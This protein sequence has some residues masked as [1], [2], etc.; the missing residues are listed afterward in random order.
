V[1]E[2]AVRDVHAYVGPAPS[3]A[4][5]GAATSLGEV[6]AAAAAAYF[7]HLAATADGRMSD[8][9]IL[10]AVIADSADVWR[11]LLGVSRDNATRGRAT[12]TNAAIWVSRFAAVKLDGHPNDL[13]WRGDEER[14]GDDARGSAVFALS[15][16]RDREG[17]PPL[18]QVARTNRDAYLRRQ[19]L[20][21]L[22]QS[23]DARALD[24]FEEILAR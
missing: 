7:L 3:R 22:G 2:G 17:I 5:D 18:I 6:P 23:G 16:L 10:P 21:W 20:F 14:D 19:A 8:R 12:R 13:A 24:L 9:A 1:E 15:Q 11:A 4:S